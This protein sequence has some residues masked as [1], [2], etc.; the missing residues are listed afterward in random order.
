M[1]SRPELGTKRTDPETGRKFYDLGKDPIVSPYTGTS[2]PL[3]FFETRS[4]APSKYAAVGAARPV[5]REEGQNDDA[6]EQD[7]ETDT[8]SLNDVEEDEGT[9]AKDDSSIDVDDD[10]AED[11]KDDND[12]TFLALDE[13]DD[14]DDVEDIVGER[15]E[16]DN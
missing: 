15:D 5:H 16:D 10:E 13:E 3:S 4:S 11:E 6:E 9:S 12:D 8:V 1:P 7:E 14:A 2:Y